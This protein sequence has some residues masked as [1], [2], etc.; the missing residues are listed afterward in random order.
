MFHKLNIINNIIF[1]SI[2]IASIALCYSC[3][4]NNCFSGSGKNST[5]HIPLTTFSHIEIHGISNILIIED[6]A[7][8]AIINGGEHIID[9]TH[10]SQLDSTIN[11]TNTTTCYMF[12]QYERP[13]I[14]IHTT[15]LKSI[16]INESCK[17]SNKGT[18][19]RD[20]SIYMNTKIAD[21]N[22]HLNNNFTNFSTYNKAGGIY[23]FSGTCT[24]AQLHAT[25]TA[26]IDARKLQTRCLTVKNHSINDFH[27]WA[28][29]TLYT[30][31]K[32]EGNIL[33]IGNPIH[34]FL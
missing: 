10:V 28:T 34:I 13:T 7:N 12:K 16:H 30:E 1:S 6:T 26:S 33:Y 23:T 5:Q 17:L 4:K 29:D 32:K 11:I 22:L 18:I 15:H 25:Y 21:I 9:Q 31:T 27:V 2:I 24:Y 3:E 14:N 19:S 8:Y 20:L